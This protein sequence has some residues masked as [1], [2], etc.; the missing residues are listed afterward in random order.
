MAG[1]STGVYDLPHLAYDPDAKVI[2]LDIMGA[3]LMASA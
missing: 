2:F 3:F 1:G